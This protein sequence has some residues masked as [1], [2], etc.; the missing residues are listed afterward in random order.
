MLLVSLG[1]C[2]DIIPNNQKNLLHET[3]IEQKL[4]I[5]LEGE[6]Y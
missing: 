6:M 5:E 3:V 2:S 4:G 1:E